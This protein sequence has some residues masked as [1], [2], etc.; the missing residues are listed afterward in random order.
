MSCIYTPHTLA[1]KWD[2]SERHIRNLIKKGELRAFP[3]GRKL[4]RI[5]ADAVEEFEQCPTTKSDGC[6]ESSALSSTKTASGTV[7]PLEPRTRARRNAA[8][9]GFTQ[10]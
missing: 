5:P 7:T 10:I 8:R 4:L 2:C 1:Q 3:L 9:R 6:E